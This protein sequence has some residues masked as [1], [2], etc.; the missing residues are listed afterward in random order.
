MVCKPKNTITEESI[1]NIHVKISVDG[2][3]I[4]L[5]QLIWNTEHSI[6]KE[7][8]P[9]IGEHFSNFLQEKISGINA[10]RLNQAMASQIDILTAQINALNCFNTGA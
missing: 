6:G 10:E 5:H 7:Y 3:S 2:V 8:V 1:S 9:K 4:N